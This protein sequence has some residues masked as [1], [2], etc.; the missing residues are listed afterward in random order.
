LLLSEITPKWESICQ[1]YG[2]HPT[3]ISR[4]SA[5]AAQIALLTD[6][7]DAVNR[8]LLSIVGDP[9]V[10]A[11]LFLKFLQLLNEGAFLK[12]RRYSFAVYI[13]TVLRHLAKGHFKKRRPVEQRLD[14][15]HEVIDHRM[16]TSG[17]DD[18]QLV[19]RRDAVVSRAWDS[20]KGFY[21]GT[22]KP[23]GHVIRL[24]VE[25]PG[26]TSAEVAERLAVLLRKEISADWVRKFRSVARRKFAGHLLDEV[27]A[28]L[29]DPT[30]AA[31]KQ[32]L[33]NLGLHVFFR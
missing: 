4:E 1:I 21:E 13:T 3:F 32:E 20:L 11:D 10:S 27:K 33:I 17:T 12:A 19:R 31:V 29:D 30:D 28:S 15:A 8:Y 26:L 9:D 23:L 18:E 24:R 6:Y 7:A 22:G 2:V 14:D 16:P 5:L 25:H